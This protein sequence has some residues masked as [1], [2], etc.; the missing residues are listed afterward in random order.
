MFPKNTRRP[1]TADPEI[2]LARSRVDL[3][4]E[5]VFGAL[6]RQSIEG[7]VQIDAIL[8]RS[9]RR[10]WQLLFFTFCFLNDL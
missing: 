4:T 7:I 9:H 3:S 2:R 6:D 5:H 1:A 8:I 10:I